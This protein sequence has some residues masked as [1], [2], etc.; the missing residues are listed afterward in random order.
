MVRTIFRTSLLASF[1]LSSMF[2]LGANAQSTWSTDAANAAF[3]QKPLHGQIDGIDFKPL[4]A[5]RVYQR[6]G[7]SGGQAGRPDS[8]DKISFKDGGG[9][10]I[11]VTIFGGSKFEDVIYVQSNLI[12]L[13]GAARLTVESDLH[14]LS[15]DEFAIRLSLGKIS[16]DKRQPIYIVFRNNHNNWMEGYIYAQVHERTM[17]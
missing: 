8:A 1:L 6:T 3:V 12:H 10:Q 14:K 2:C 5:E 9:R 4:I 11:D 7:L 15:A 13:K 16:S 17:F